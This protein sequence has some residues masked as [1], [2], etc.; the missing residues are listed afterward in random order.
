M[1]M[2][3]VVLILLVLTAECA[4]ACTSAVV[5]GRATRDGRPILWKQRDTG[6]LENKL[7]SGQ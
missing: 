1:L 4:P 7:V 5:S 3:M 2:R 6:Q